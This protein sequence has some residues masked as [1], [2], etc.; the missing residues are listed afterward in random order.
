MNNPW[1]VLIADDEPIIREGVRMAIDWSSLD[2]EVV[3][4]AEDGEEAL[5]LALQHQVNILL[6][7]LNMPIM[8]GITLMKHIRESLPDARLIIITGHDEFQYARE[9]I[10]LN[11]AE[12]VLKPANPAQLHQVLEEV[13][14]GLEEEWKQKKHLLLASR[15]IRR[16]YPL[17]S[18]RFCLEWIEGNLSEA[19]IL[20]Q[21]EFLQ[22]PAG[23]P[24]WIGVIRWSDPALERT[25]IKESD[26]Q[27]TMFAVENITG[28]WLQD[29]RHI[30]FRDTGG[31]IC[32][33]LWGACDESI[34]SSISD[35]IIQYLKLSVTL[36]FKPVTG[37]L[38][39]VP[40]VYRE[41]KQEVYRDA[42]LS[43]IVRRAKLYLQEHYADRSLTLEKM[44]EDLKCNPVYLSRTL[45]Q[46]LGVSFCQ[47]LTDMRMK[48]AV[49]L[50]GATDLSILEISE[51]LG[52]ETQHYFSK[53]FKKAMGVSPN[54]YRRGELV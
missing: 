36:S 43:P 22:L 48:K 44:A 19:E 46:E 2:M 31:L 15:Q 25:L 51:Q 50:L 8:D 11:V 34:F 12:Y 7:D 1:K 29:V 37:K 18:E 52:Y 21:M 26:R 54:Q 27:L 38:E 13:R 30:L 40:Q 35:S 5:E 4:E 9:A 53:V 16:S 24:S 45:K 17:L 42:R 14:K 28:E 3:A 47:L 10:R 32:V 23:C 49:E 33:I 39:D 20:E 6:V 41:A